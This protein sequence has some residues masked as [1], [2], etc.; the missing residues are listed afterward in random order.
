MN[1]AAQ[2]LGSKP[3]LTVYTMEPTASA[4]RPSA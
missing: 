3:D 4:M 1:T 2:I